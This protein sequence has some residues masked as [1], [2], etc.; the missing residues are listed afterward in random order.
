MPASFTGTSRR[1]DIFS[2]HARNRREMALANDQLV[3][4]ENEDRRHAGGSRGE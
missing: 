4:S 1:G 2:K 3:D